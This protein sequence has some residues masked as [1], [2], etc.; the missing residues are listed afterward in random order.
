MTSSDR[1]GGPG[2]ALVL[3]DLQEDYLADPDLAR[4]RTGLVR[5]AN[6]L[7]RRAARSGALA[8]EVR[9]EHL[10]DRS[11]WAR[12]M[13]QDDQGVALAGTPGAARLPELAPVESVV[14]KT[15]DSAFFRTSLAD[16]L[17]S[18]AVEQVVLAGVSTES[19]IAATATDAYAHDLHVVLVEDAIGCADPHLHDHT[20]GMLARLYRQEVIRAV[21]VCF[22]PGRTGAYRHLPAPM[23][24]S[25][26]R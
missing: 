11:T 7:L 26:S 3:V 15:R 16:L 4:H 13:L 25:A 14:T 5:A 20:L 10:P 1:A 2:T 9:T 17:V 22:R 24:R 23:W 19:C 12:N 6:Q 18:R 21:D 8:F